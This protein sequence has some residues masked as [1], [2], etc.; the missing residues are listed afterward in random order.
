LDGWFQPSLSNTRN[1]EST[2]T[3]KPRV[4]NIMIHSARWMRV[5][6]TPAIRFEVENSGIETLIGA[7]VGAGLGAAR[8]GAGTDSDGAGPE[9]ASGAIAADAGTGFGVEVGV[10]EGVGEADEVRRARRLARC[11]VGVGRRDS[12]S[13]ENNSSGPKPESDFFF[14]G[15]R[16]C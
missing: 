16:F 9:P 2:N 5:V 10:G 8:S 15:G 4:V 12:C 1:L 13:S 7:V 6:R 14:S 11:G 3:N